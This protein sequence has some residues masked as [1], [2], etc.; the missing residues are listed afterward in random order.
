M[1]AYLLKRR[2]F[3][4]KTFA[5]NFIKFDRMLDVELIMI[6]IAVQIRPS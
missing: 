6:Q 3:Y 2:A 5:G 4:F 1:K